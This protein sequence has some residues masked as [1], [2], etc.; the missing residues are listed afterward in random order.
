MRQRHVSRTL[1]GCWPSS[2]R[3]PGVTAFFRMVECSTCAPGYPG[4]GGRIIAG[5]S[6]SPV[7]SA[8]ASAPWKGAGTPTEKPGPPPGPPGLLHPSRV[9]RVGGIGPGGWK[10]RLE[11]FKKR[12]S[13]SADNSPALQRW[14]PRSRSNPVP[15]GTKGSWQARQPICRPRGT[16][17]RGNHRPRAEALGYSQQKTATSF[18]KLLYCPATPAGVAKGGR[19]ALNQFV[20][21][22]KEPRAIILPPL[23]GW[24]EGNASPQPTRESGMP[25]LERPDLTVVP[26]APSSS[27]AVRRTTARQA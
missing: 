23:P 13:H 24:P 20:K 25:R 15:S 2:G 18:L 27:R 21:G 17:A 16:G 12:R 26:P 5:G 1:P 11:H 3:A 7:T 10:P 19:L 6:L 9:R 14:G 22:C 4:R 8:S